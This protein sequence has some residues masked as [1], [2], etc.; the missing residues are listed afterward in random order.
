MPHSNILKKI[1]VLLQVINDGTYCQSEEVQS[2]QMKD[3]DVTAIGNTQH[4]QGLSEHLAK[5]N[6]S[7]KFI[8]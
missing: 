6:I 1:Q 4:L 5:T 7:A 3:T 2:E 8:A